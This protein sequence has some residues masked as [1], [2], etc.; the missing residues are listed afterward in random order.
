MVAYVAGGY[1]IVGSGVVNSL[2]QSGAKCCVS[3]RSEK[4]FNELKSLVPAE[5][6]GNLSFYKAD[7][8]NEAETA[9]VRDEIVKKEGQI[10]HVV[11]SVGGWRTD[12]LLSSLST[13]KYLKG[14]TDLTLPHFVCYKTFAPLLAKQPKSTYTFITGG[15]GEAKFFDPKASMLPVGAGALYGMF[16]SA[17][18]EYKANKNVSFIELRLFF[19]IR[20]QLDSKFDPKKSQLEV[21]HDYVGKFVPK[22]ILKGKSDIYKIQTRSIGDQL[23]QKL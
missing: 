9:R 17:V 7:L 1:G 5:H 21:G 15:S 2:L 10:N 16:T 4:G 23:F 3:G 22:L 12:G 18:S 6:H 20:R 13:E 11:V 19:W 8:T 14:V